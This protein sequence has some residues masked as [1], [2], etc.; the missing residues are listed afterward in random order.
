MFKCTGLSVGKYVVLIERD[1]HVKIGSQHSY[2]QMEVHHT[3]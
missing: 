1:R 2:Y 3:L